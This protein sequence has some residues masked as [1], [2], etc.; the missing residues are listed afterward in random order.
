M[1]FI[2]PNS[3][4]DDPI[5]LIYFFQKG[6]KHQPA[7]N[8]LSI[9]GSVILTRMEFDWETWH[10]DKYAGCWQ[11]DP[12]PRVQYVGSNV[13]NHHQ[14]VMEFLVYNQPVIITNCEDVHD[15]TPAPWTTMY[16]SVTYGPN[17]N[18]GALS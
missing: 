16:L 17:P 15:S 7:F 18:T 12:M 4:D 10:V 9:L 3:W 11:H 2:F 6:S 13:S 5:W 1:A 14:S 8:L